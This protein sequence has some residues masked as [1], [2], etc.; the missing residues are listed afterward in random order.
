MKWKK[1]HMLKISAVYLI[2]NP[3][4]PIHYTSL[5]QVEQ[6]LFLLKKSFGNSMV[7]SGYIVCTQLKTDIFWQPFLILFLIVEKF[8][9]FPF[10][11]NP[12]FKQQVH[13]IQEN[14]GPSI[15]PYKFGP[16]FTRIKQKNIFWIKKFKMA[17]FSKFFQVH[18]FKRTWN[19]KSEQF[20]VIEKR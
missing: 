4:I 13:C 9:G 16:I 8:D 7:S 6:A 10:L 18:H 5:G 2:G 1:K 19:F 3:E 20:F 11:M 17:D 15:L 12:K 14:F